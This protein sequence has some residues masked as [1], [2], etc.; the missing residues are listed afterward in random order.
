MSLPKKNERSSLELFQSRLENIVAANHEL[1]KL[2]HLIDWQKLEKIFG[3][4]YIPKKGRTAI[5]TRLMVGLLYLKHVNNLSDEQVVLVWRE[6]PYWQ[7]FCGEVYFQHEVPIHPTSLTRFRNRIGEEGC[8]LLLQETINVGLKTDVVK[9]SEIAK[10]NVDT[11][12]QPKAIKYPSD[13]SLQHQCRNNLVKLCRQHGIKLRQTFS[14]LSKSQLLRGNRYA[15]ARQMRRA[16][17]CFKKIKIYLGRVCRDIERK[18]SDHRHQRAHF[19]DL[20]LKA[21]R[22]LTQRR[23]DKNKL[24]SLHAPEVECIAKG[25]SHKKYEFGSKV[26]IATTSRSN[27]IVGIQSLDRNQYDGHSL[28]SALAQVKRLTNQSPA[29]VF[30]D[31]GYRGHDA[32][33]S[34]VFICGS[35]RASVTRTLKR[36]LKRR[37]AIEPVIGHL[38]SD[39]SLSRNHYKGRLGDKI[40]AIMSGACHN[41]RKI[42][43]KLRFFYFC[44]LLFI[45][46]GPVT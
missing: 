44:W 19:A 10:I 42:L 36:D 3:A 9:T 28:G 27:F 18:I 40:N 35:R 38:K 16:K 39:G 21:R 41:L 34:T 45:E 4:F 23:D 2:S 8:E 46:F 12:V 11:T 31:R 22:L 7:Y 33:E 29:K 32:Q 14:R 20:L 17:M 43:K 5:P 1:V 15:F 6:N 30:V 37:S 24:Y 26:S 25:K 13:S